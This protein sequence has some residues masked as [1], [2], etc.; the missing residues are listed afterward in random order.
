MTGIAEVGVPNA[1]VWH[2]A[3]QPAVKQAGLFKNHKLRPQV[4]QTFLLGLGASEDA[5]FANMK[6]TARRNIRQAEKEIIISN[7]PAQLRELYKFQRA[8][9]EGK[10]KL[11]WPYNA[12]YLQKIMDACVAHSACAL[13]VA[14]KEG[15]TQAIVWQVCVD[16]T[17]S[18]YLM[19][20]Q[21]QDSTSYKAMSALAVA[22]HKGGEENGSPHVRL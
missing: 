21:N 15:A 7:E 13:W 12:A 11:S 8:T 5:L 6:D 4:Q 18:Y 1:D 20:A 14:K 17:C 10:G 19:G 3:L 16:A 2:L 22:C 9:L